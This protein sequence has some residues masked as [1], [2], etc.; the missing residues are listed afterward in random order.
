ML[1][2]LLWMCS[3]ANA[4]ADGDNGG[5]LEAPVALFAAG[6]QERFA[7]E[8]TVAH[9]PLASSAWRESEASRNGVRRRDTHVPHEPLSYF[10]EP[11][12]PGA[13]ELINGSAI[14]VEMDIRSCSFETAYLNLV[15]A[16]ATGIFLHHEIFVPG[17]W[18]DKWGHDARNNLKASA[19]TVPMVEISTSVRDALA[20]R[21]AN[22]LP[23]EPVR[24]TIQPGSN[25]FTELF[26]SKSWF[27]VARCLVPLAYFGVV[28]TGLF[29]A[30]S[31]ASSFQ[32]GS[33]ASW[34]VG[35]EMVPAAVLAIASPLGIYD[36]TF[37]NRETQNALRL[38]FMATEL[39][40][41]V[42]VARYWSAVAS[43]FEANRNGERHE[44]I[45]DPQLSTTTTVFTIMALCGDFIFTV[46]VASSSQSSW[47]SVS[48]L[49][50]QHGYSA[51]V[52][53]AGI[54]CLIYFA[55][56]SFRVVRSTNATSSRQHITR[57]IL[58]S[59]MFMLGPC[60]VF[61]ILTAST[62]IPTGTF[63]AIVA[64]KHFSRAGTGICQLL[65][66]LQQR[67]SVHPEETHAS[68]LT[69]TRLLAEQHNQMVK[70]RAD[71]AKCQKEAT[72]SK[73]REDEQTKA[74]LRR[75][76]EA[77]ADSNLNHTLKVLL[78]LLP[79]HYFLFFISKCVASSYTFFCPIKN[80]MGSARAGIV[81]ALEGARE[82]QCGCHFCPEHERVRHAVFFL[83]HHFI[84]HTP[85]P[86]LVHC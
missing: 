1:V 25:T 66:F 68:S 23:D 50:L 83:F 44:D 8:V 53:V 13:T 51:L 46:V 63:F 73:K 16:G 57:Y 67:S 39:V 37:F 31:Q 71:I 35:I 21:L 34:V 43:A 17:F 15:A 72:E 24:V 19:Q 69:N 40:S 82:G 12:Q 47:V 22:A 9:A 65:V 45:R 58:A 84:F 70:L 14:I 27:I 41:S 28:A 62:S 20:Q 61:G 33:T 52:T 75:K 59:C 55:H 5:V 76:R 26:H 42:L 78:S 4:S 77:D 48:M 81:L 60:V 79:F 30:S 85:P 64:V 18:H 3:I 86:P 54:G 10:C 2:V 38:S 29:V 7:V 80:H 32:L 74:A 11:V 49:T 56:V 36:G 6:P